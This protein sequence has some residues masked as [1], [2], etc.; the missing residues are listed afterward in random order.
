MALTITGLLADDEVIIEGV[1]CIDDSFP[2]F[3]QRMRE[4]GAEIQ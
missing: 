2:G 1:R 4:L 3:A